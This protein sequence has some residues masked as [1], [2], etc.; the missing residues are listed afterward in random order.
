MLLSILVYTYVCIMCVY[1]YI[2]T[3]LYKSMCCHCLQAELKWQD[4]LPVE[5]CMHLAIL[6]VFCC[7]LFFVSL[8]LCRFFSAS[9]LFFLGWSFLSRQELKDLRL[10]V[11]TLAAEADLMGE[12][13][14][15]AH[16]PKG[17]PT[18]ILAKQATWAGFPVGLL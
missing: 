1:I 13:T 14:Q 2:Y 5:P 8:F 17:Y 3:H 7:C 9:N 15:T 18:K 16:A 4:S 11:E 6:P 10:Q 12:R